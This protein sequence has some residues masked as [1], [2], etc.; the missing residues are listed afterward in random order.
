MAEASQFRI[1]TVVAALD[2]PTRRRI[3]QV[4]L[5]QDVHVSALARMLAVSRPVVHVHLA[6]LA[7]AGLVSSRREFSADGKALRTFSVEPFDIHLTPQNIAAEVAAVAQ[8]K[9]Q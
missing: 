9:E 5:N 1:G 7:E 3:I 6:Q 4:L 2:H 8:S